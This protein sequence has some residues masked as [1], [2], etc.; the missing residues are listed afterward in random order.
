MSTRNRSWVFTENSEPRLLAAALEL[1]GPDP[2]IKY[3]VGQ[4]EQG[5]HEHF[6]GYVQ[7]KTNCTLRW[8]QKHL[9]PT[10]HYEVARGTPDQNIAYCTKEDTRIEGP[11]EYGI[12]PC[13]GARNDLAQIKEKLD[14]GTPMKEIAQ[15]HFGSFV[16]Y[17]K[18][19]E[20]YKA[21]VQTP[22]QGPVETYVFYGPSGT[23]KTT[24][25][26]SMFPGAYIKSPQT[27][28]WDDY[29]DQAV[30]I[31]DEH[32]S[33]WFTWDY[34]LRMIDPI[35]LP[36]TVET[37]GGTRHLQATTFVFTCNTSYE[38]W[39]KDASNLDA[40]RRRLTHYWTFVAHDN[41][42]KVKPF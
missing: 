7:L 3:L 22:R 11:F 17:S 26:T 40:L 38:F 41:I 39:Y 13:Q 19:F 14:A 27:K 29:E 9:S 12:R 2:G 8:L 30:V 15:E 35:G 42:N 4:L 10:A 20:K 37:K 18:G 24:L 31:L 21:L 36:F 33:A 16:R 1:E 25:A 34:L 5:T 28:W 23:G 32:N 6:Q